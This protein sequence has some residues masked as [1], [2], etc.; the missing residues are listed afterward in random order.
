LLLGLI[1]VA[2]YFAGLYKMGFA[3]GLIAFTITL[4][5]FVSV[6]PIGVAVAL[7]LAGYGLLPTSHAIRIL[8]GACDSCPALRRGIAAEIAEAEKSRAYRREM[9]MSSSSA[10]RPTTSSS[11]RKPI[12][13][14][15]T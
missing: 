12:P 6:W 1:A 11:A 7:A 13:S 8:T 4:L 3:A 10:P 5:L 14:K 9:L 15:S 2:F